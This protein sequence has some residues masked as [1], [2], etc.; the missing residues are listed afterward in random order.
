MTEKDL[1]EIVGE[2]AE[3]I[4]EIPEIKAELQKIF[5]REVTGGSSPEDA[6]KRAMEPVYM[7]AIATL[8]GDAGIEALH[9]VLEEKL[10]KRQQKYEA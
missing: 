8:F 5:I 2:R 4:A 6:M 3:E 9:D 1:A 10:N 7:V